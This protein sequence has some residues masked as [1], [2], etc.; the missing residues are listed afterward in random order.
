MKS[1]EEPAGKAR[2]R[3]NPREE[4]MGHPL[5][6]PLSRKI[7]PLGKETIVSLL[8]CSGVIACSLRQ[9][10]FFAFAGMFL[11]WGAHNQ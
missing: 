4:R 1:P 8:R 2:M 6:G 7:L 5:R 3:R 9:S 10:L 11:G